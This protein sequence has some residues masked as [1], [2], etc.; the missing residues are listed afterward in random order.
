MNKFVAV[1]YNNSENYRER[2]IRI[3]FCNDFDAAKKY[4]A[5]KFAMAWNDTGENAE[6]SFMGHG[7][8]GFTTCDENWLLQL[9]INKETRNWTSHVFDCDT[10]TDVIWE[11]YDLSSDKN[12]E[13]EAV[14]S[15]DPVPVPLGGFLQEV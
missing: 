6:A 5:K 3:Y 14:I 4:V 11:I 15:V 9:D 10:H 7:I 8:T 2:A 1:T 13:W 12:K